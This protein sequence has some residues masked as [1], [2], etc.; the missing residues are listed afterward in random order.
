MFHSHYLWID[1]N[2]MLGKLGSYQS[3]RHTINSDIVRPE[4]KSGQ[5]C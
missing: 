1:L 4:L 2:Y 3:G 5:L